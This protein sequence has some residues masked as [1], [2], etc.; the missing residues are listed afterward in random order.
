[1]LC[2]WGCWP[3][4]LRRFTQIVA[5]ILG[6]PSFLGQGKDRLAFVEDLILAGEIRTTGVKILR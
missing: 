5:L 1:M 2:P 6:F 3:T 4:D